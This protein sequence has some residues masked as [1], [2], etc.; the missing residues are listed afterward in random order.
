M[1]EEDDD[2]DDD[3]DEDLFSL[4]CVLLTEGSI[5]DHCYE[6]R[7]NKGVQIFE[8][9]GA[10]NGTGYRRHCRTPTKPKC[11]GKKVHQHW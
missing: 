5:P 6:I 7:G 8:S 10:G 3:D 9:L 4:Y 11:G 2:D 1:E